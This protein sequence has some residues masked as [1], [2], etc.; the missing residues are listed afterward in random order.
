LPVFL[1]LRTMMMN[2]QLVPL[3]RRAPGGIGCKETIRRDYA[4]PG[5]RRRELDAER[6]AISLP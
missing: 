5:A 3:E 4:P 2:R 1:V 6:G